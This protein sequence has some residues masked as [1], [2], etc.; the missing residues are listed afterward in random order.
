[1]NKPPGAEPMK[2]AVIGQGVAGMSAAWLLSQRHEVTV[3]EA[4][5]RFGGHSHT[6]EAGG[7]QGPIPVDMG[8]IVYN[9]ANYPNLAALFRHLD[10][11]TAF[12]DMSFGVSLDDG[13]LEYA[14]TDLTTLFAQ[15]RNLLRPRFWS[16]LADVVRFCRHAPGHA[17]ALDADM[18]S[19]GDY[20][21]EAGYSRAFQDDHILPQAAAI[22][23]ASVDA[24]RDLPAAAFIRFFE[25][26]GLL[27]ILDKPLWRTVV[28]GSRAYVRKLTAGLA[29]NA[30]LGVA[31]TGVQRI[32][33][34]VLVRDARGQVDWYD[35]VVI[36]CHADQG[37]A[38][39]DRPT[40]AERDILGAFSYTPNEAVLHADAGF[41]PKRRKA[42]SSWNYLGG[43]GE[44]GRRRL[45]VTYWMNLL[46]GLPREQPLFVTLNPVRP[47]DPA[48]VIRTEHY[49]HPLFDAAALRSQKRLWSLQGE[50]GVWWCGAYFGAGFHED[51]LQ[52]GLAV[53][54][55]LGVV[56]RPWTVAGESGR[57]HLGPAPPTP[58]RIS[59]AAA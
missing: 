39:L 58:A 27:K 22:W 19:L 14:S 25:N 3:Y 35:Q 30:R 1:M 50:G 26:H 42:W 7:P 36:A 37:L 5:P 55:A 12:T 43:A 49:R 52:S 40:A 48:T 8:F 9:E 6:V 29:A 24:V 17:C 11:E 41:M 57:I 23:S 31:A 4:E 53:A 21:G 56:R 38:L 32:G 15:P 47:P 2:I 51:G 45:C 20:L 10:V 13:G 59:E 28:G 16:M 54:E 33:D 18:T 44:A 46:Q 34:G